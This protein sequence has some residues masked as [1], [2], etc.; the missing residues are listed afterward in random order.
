M[1]Q[2][3]PNTKEAERPADTSTAKTETPQPE[4]KTETQP[5]QPEKVFGREAMKPEDVRAAS[6]EISGLLKENTPQSIFKAA[7]ELAHLK[8]AKINVSEKH[9]EEVLNQ[10]LSQREEMQKY[11]GPAT[12]RYLTYLKYLGAI[13]G[14][15][16]KEKRVIEQG[17]RERTEKGGVKNLKSQDLTQLC[18]NAKYLGV[19]MPYGSMTPHFEQEIERVNKP[20]DEHRVAYRLARAKYLGVS[21]EIEYC[22]GKN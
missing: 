4:V 19:E 12:A 15:D 2:R 13:E 11:G 18:V 22:G 14:I 1:L 3:P 21:S 16:D 6:Q 7:R 20:G 17:I 8:R 10:L 9:R 5:R